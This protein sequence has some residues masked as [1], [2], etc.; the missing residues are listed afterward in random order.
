M[1]PT[2]ATSANARIIIMESAVLTCAYLFQSQQVHDRERSGSSRSLAACTAAGDIG[3]IWLTYPDTSATYDTV[4]VIYVE[5]V[6]PPPGLE[7]PE[8]AECFFDPHIHA[9]FRR[10]HRAAFGDQIADRI[11]PYYRK[12]R[13]GAAVSCQVPPAGIISSIPNAPAANETVQHE[14]DA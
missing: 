13:Q 8:F 1:K 5:T 9:A 14:H 3:I 10:H 12:Y 6:A 11:C 2:A 4:A 7:S